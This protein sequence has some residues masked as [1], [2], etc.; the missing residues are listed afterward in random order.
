MNFTT[1]VCIP[2]P[3]R[4]DG[5]NIPLLVE[6]YR[7]ILIKLALCARPISHMSIS[8]PYLVSKNRYFLIFLCFFFT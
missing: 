8:I 2:G 4:L 5:D 6:I 3:L 1:E 7:F